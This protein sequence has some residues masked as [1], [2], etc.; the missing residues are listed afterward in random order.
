VSSAR[1]Q[2]ECAL[3]IL[4]GP[5]HVLSPAGERLCERLQ[6]LIADAQRSAILST[7]VETP[8]L[9]ACAAAIEGLTRAFLAARITRLEAE[10]ALVDA[11]V[12]LFR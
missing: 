9:V 11:C 3:A 10:T 1:A 8:R 12:R 6:V 5:R 2:V 4:P 7:R